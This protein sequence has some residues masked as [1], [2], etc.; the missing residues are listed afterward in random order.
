MKR[1]IT[2]ELERWKAR[3]DRKSL[4]IRGARQIGKT[5]SIL[6]FA[7]KHYRNVVYF[8]FNSDETAS[9]AFDGPLN[10]D[11]SIGAVLRTS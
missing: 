11:S 8:D 10:V 1:K 4:L 9:K 5:Y 2:A 3:E 7:E 6:D